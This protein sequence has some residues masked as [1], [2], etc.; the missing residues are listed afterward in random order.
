MIQHSFHHMSYLKYHNNLQRNSTG[1]HFV[2]DIS[3][4]SDCECLT[5]FKLYNYTHS[6]NRPINGT[7][8][9]NSIGSGVFS[10]VIISQC[11]L[12]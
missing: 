8:Q 4:Y 11:L 6:V 1:F 12:E 7:I 2:H 5:D 10:N 3:I 9:V